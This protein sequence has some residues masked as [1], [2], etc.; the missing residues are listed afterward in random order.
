MPP[1][2]R[3]WPADHAPT[4]FQREV[5]EAVAALQPGEVVTYSEIALELGRPRAAQ[6]VANVLRCAPGLPWWRVVPS[7][8]RVYGSHAA[9]QVPLLEADGLRVDEHR[10]VHPAA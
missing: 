6:A 7:D 4:P 9:V 5:V 8:G 2:A 1:H 10:R 3:P